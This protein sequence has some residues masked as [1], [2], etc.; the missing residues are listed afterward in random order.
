M[1]INRDANLR[2]LHNWFILNDTFTKIEQNEIQSRAYIAL[3]AL[4]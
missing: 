1:Q 4:K 3:F 2:I